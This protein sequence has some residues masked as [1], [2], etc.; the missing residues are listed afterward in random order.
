M[1]QFSTQKII[2]FS[3][4]K[5]ETM[6]SVTV[7]TGNLVIEVE[8]GSGWVVSDTLIYDYAGKMATY[9]ARMRFTPTGNCTYSIDTRGVA[10]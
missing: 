9:G 4:A 8:D 3:D 6:I 5:D 7:G 1:K 10:Q 2:D